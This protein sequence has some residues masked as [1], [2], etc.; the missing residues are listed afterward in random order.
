MCTVDF[1]TT[2]QEEVTQGALQENIIQSRLK[3]LYLVTSA[4]CV[5][6]ICW[7][8][9]M[10]SSWL[11]GR[12]E[13]HDRIL[14]SMID[15]HGV[16]PPHILSKYEGH[17]AVHLTHIL[18]GALWAGM[19]PLQL[20][21]T[22]RKQRP[23]LHRMSGYVFMACTLLMTVGIFI[24]LKRKLLFD[25]FFNIPDGDRNGDSFVPI[26]I[27][28]IYFSTTALFALHA[29]RSRQFQLHQRWIIRH[30][31]SGIWI[32]V[33]RMLLMTVYQLIYMARPV[34]PESQKRA[35][36]EA[37]KVAIVVC[38]ILGEYANHLLEASKRKKT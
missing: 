3:W 27:M 38:V 15:P 29:A 18:P 37:S 28:T 9:V 16:T 22:F 11:I 6:M 21:Q 8:L 7:I 33:Q 30:I 20:H 2:P 13:L 36:G 23:R 1:S 35:F 24:I 5:M 19:I 34:P 25:H 26:V 31:A 14:F 12:S 32:A 17:T 4:F 10:P